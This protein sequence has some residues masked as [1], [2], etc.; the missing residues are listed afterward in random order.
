MQKIV[1]TNKINAIFRI[2]TYFII[3]INSIANLLL[4]NPIRRVTFIP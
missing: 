1:I 2:I 3:L 4:E